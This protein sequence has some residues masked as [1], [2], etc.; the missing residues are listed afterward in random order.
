MPPRGEPRGRGQGGG[1]GPRG[2]APSRGRGGAAPRGR[3]RGAASAPA[4]I[5]VGTT[6][7]AGHVETVG[8]KR[9]G[10]GRAG[11][12]TR[13]MTNHFPVSIPKDIIYHYDGAPAMR[14]LIL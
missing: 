13:V 9:P 5:Q 14:D 6:Q 11:R 10:V 1:A 7:Q 3:G 8:V 2:A 12:G 4:G